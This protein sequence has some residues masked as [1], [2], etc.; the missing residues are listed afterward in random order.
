[1]DSRLNSSDYSK[2]RRSDEQ[3]PKKWIIRKGIFL[4]ISLL[5]IGI[6]SIGAIVLFYLTVDGSSDL[7]VHPPKNGANAVAGIVSSEMADDKI[8]KVA[9]EEESSSLKVTTE[10]VAATDFSD[11]NKKCDWN[12]ILINASNEVPNDFH[13]ALGNCKGCQMD[14][15]V[16]DDLTKMFNDASE[17]GVTLW[18]SSAYRS[19]ELQTELFEDEIQMNLSAGRSEE[20]AIRLAQTAVAKPRTSEHHTG[21]AVDLNGVQE[22]FYTTDAYR[23]LSEHAH[24]Y[25]FILRYPEDKRDITKIIFE[26]WH[27]R[28]VGKDHA[29]KIK[30]SGLCF[31]EYV[32]NLMN[33]Q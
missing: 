15:R 19:V 17:D 12:L 29:I 20:E 1:M 10:D 23:W 21:L 22:D 2:F 14:V 27:Y 13:V 18:I 26:P 5:L 4:T 32:R 30:Q 8:E 11:W 33:N 7:S 24:E 6:F 28:Y 3:S 25:G 16:I 9:S 31:E